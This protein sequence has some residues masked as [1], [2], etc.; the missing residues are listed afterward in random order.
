MSRW[1]ETIEA[2]TDEA[3]DAMIRQRR[4]DARRFAY[5]QDREI[6]HHE[7]RT[8]VNGKRVAVLTMIDFWEDVE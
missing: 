4:L 1:I 2:E 6:V 8:I 3:L 5:K 7:Q